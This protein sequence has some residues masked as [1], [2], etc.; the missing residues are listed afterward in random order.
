[1]RTGYTNL[2]LH[3]GAAPRWLFNRMTKLARAMS[4]IIL[5]EYGPDEFLRRISD[6]FWFQSLGCVLGFDWHSSGLTTTLCGALK[7][8]LKDLGK[9]FG[10][11]IAGGKGKTSRK[12]PDEI[13]FWAEQMSFAP[14]QM[15]YASRMSAKVDSCAVQDDYQI[16]H[17]TFFGTKD[18]KWA[19]V[20][21]GMN[22]HTRWAR[23]YHWLSLDLADFVVE[24]HKAI[25]SDNKGKILNMVAKESEPARKISTKIAAQEPD[26]SIKEYQ[27]I[28]ELSLPSR[29][30]IL[31]RDINPQRFEKI[32]VKTYEEQPENFEALLGVKGVGPQTI[33]ALA[34]ISEVVYGAKPSFFD[35]VSYTFAHGG[36]DGYPYPINQND[37]DKSIA[38]LE[39]AIR[40][41]KIGN[42]DKLEA[43][44][45]FAIITKTT[46]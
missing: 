9:D 29:H 24:P 31:S 26:K 23:R 11:F 4:E 22:T 28:K 32:L 39:K 14:E 16:Y 35:P 36:K 40:T 43:L 2:P 5:G 13:K 38:V 33:R 6:P 20:Q 37:Y 45:R 1:M 17:H 7:Q 8:G 12:T 15:V 30:P 3:Y 27:K 21:Q 19:V 34:L 46:G 44:K 25:V 41:A 10:I 42:S 18:G